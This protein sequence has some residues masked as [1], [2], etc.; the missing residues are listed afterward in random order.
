MS[1]FFCKR[2]SWIVMIAFGLIL[3][4]V[5]SFIGRITDGF[6]IDLKDASVVQRNPDNLLS[7]KYDGSGWKDN[8]Y[9]VGDGYTLTAKKNGT[10]LI[11][12]EYTGASGKTEI[13]LEILTLSAGTYTI[14]GASGGGNAT[15]YL[16][17]TAGGTDYI[18]DFGAE[19]GTFTLTS[20][21]DVTVSLVI[22]GEYKFENVKIQPVVVEGSDPGSFSK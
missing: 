12:G 22:F 8:T 4:L 20:P 5:I 9:N 15:Y 21:G 11:N 16:K 18:A 1:K 14:S 13:P 6:Q 19:D 2:P 17:A 7:G 3:I 10:I